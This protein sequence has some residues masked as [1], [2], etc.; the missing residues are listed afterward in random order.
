MIMT[1]PRIT[2]IQHIVL[3]LH[4]D[5]ACFQRGEVSTY[6]DADSNINVGCTSMYQDKFPDE[7]DMGRQTTKHDTLMLGR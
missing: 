7:V 2:T 3:N 5:R 4:F 6:S 1:R